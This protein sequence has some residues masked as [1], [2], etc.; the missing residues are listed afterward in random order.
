MVEGRLRAKALMRRFNTHP[1]VEWAPG[2]TAA[3]AFGPEEKYEILGE[4]FGLEGIE[5]AYELCIEPP[6]FC[7]YV[8]QGGR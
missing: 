5:K 3:D 8:S 7:D 6:F 1:G 4:L 2:V